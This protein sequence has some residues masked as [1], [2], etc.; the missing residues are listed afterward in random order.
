MY[1]IG[2]K[3]CTGDPLE[4]FYINR[5]YQKKPKLINIDFFGEQKN[6]GKVHKKIKCF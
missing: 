6:S 3:I 1:K 5:F 2:S 4:F